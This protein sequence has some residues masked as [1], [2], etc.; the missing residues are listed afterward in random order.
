MEIGAR[1]RE[2]LLRLQTELCAPVGGVL[3][4]F[5]DA[6]MPAL[7]KE[8]TWLVNRNLSIIAASGADPGPETKAALYIHHV[9]AHRVKRAGLIY[10]YAPCCARA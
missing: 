10:L 8:A 2:L 5:D 9:A 6:A 4:P 3:P 1:A 7:A